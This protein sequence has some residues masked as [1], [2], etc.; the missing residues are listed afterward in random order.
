MPSFN[1]N[2]NRYDFKLSHY[3]TPGVV[4]LQCAAS[5]DSRLAD[6]LNDR[7]NR[8]SLSH[9]RKAWRRRYGRRLKWLNTSYQEHEPYLRALRIDPLFDSLRSDP[10]YV[11]LVRKIGFPK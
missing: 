9:R 6:V 2:A 5:Y 3:R 11:E 4:D 8:L 10:R 1:I 7:P